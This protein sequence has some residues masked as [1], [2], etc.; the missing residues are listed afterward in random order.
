MGYISVSYENLI[1]IERRLLR[2]AE[3]KPELSRAILAFSSWEALFR[4][5]KKLS[6]SACFCIG[7]GAILAANVDRLGKSTSE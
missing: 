7:K 5:F 3:T 2:T 4:D 6:C 1:E